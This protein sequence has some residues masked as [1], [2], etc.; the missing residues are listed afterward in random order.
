[1]AGISARPQG[2]C[3]KCITRDALIPCASCIGRLPDDMPATSIC[4][5]CA[6]DPLACSTF[7]SVD[8]AATPPAYT[9]TSCA[10]AQ[11]ILT[12]K[13]AVSTFVAPSP[14]KFL[15]MASVFTPWL[16]V[17]MKA[18]TEAKRTALSILKRE[19]LDTETA[20]ASALAGDISRS[21]AITKLL[22]Q[23]TDSTLDSR[24]KSLGKNALEMFA[25]Q[26]MP[27]IKFKDLLTPSRGG[28]VE[29]SL[30]HFRTFESHVD[31]LVRALAAER[32]FI[33]KEV[34]KAYIPTTSRK[35]TAPRYLS[36]EALSLTLCM[37]RRLSREIKDAASAPSES[38][39]IFQEQ[40]GH[41]MMTSSVDVM[42]LAQ[43]GSSASRHPASPPASQQASSS[44][45]L[46]SPSPTKPPKRQLPQPRA[47]PKNKRV[48]QAQP[49]A[50][51]DCIATPTTRDEAR[52][53]ISQA[54]KGP[55]GFCRNCYL[56]LKGKIQHTLPECAAA[57]N[58]CV[59]PCFLPACGG[60][61]HFK[62]DCPN[63]K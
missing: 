57:G 43:I 36:V 8:S 27:H 1:M 14:E 19:N 34:I 12:S 46:P 4:S 51:Y 44:S 60:S 26:H 54:P 32:V 39:A 28:S 37:F 53:I 18:S 58:E 62:K 42:A 5:D 41:L 49:E 35:T 7:G 10:R 2:A 13:D 50:P 15:S 61:C 16:F 38:G 45:Q 59:I 3:I 31:P 20:V 47:D 56:L 9:C 52:R 40:Y 63:K 24:V 55:L 30:T 48:K 22:A 11:A 25:R 6:K 29:R 33:L 23:Q 21:H 17:I